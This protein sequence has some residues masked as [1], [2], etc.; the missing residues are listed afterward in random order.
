MTKIMFAGFQFKANCLSLSEMTRSD[1]CPKF[2]SVASFMSVTRT[3]L[4]IYEISLASNLCSHISSLRHNKMLI[5]I[6]ISTN[7]TFTNLETD[8]LHMSCPKSAPFWPCA[9]SRALFTVKLRSKL[10]LNKYPFA[11]INNSNEA[12]TLMVGHLVAFLTIF[13]IANRLF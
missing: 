1:S 3:I 10:T 13:R 4:I 8:Q 12:E 9:P 6:Q 7:R 2:F 5:N 11:N